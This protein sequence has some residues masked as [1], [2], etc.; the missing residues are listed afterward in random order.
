MEDQAKT[1]AQLIAELNELREQVV[2]SRSDAEEQDQLLG[3]VMGSVQEGVIVYGPDL[4]YRFWNQFMEELTGVPASKI[5]GRPSQEVFPFLRKVGVIDKLDQALAGMVPAPT[6]YAY[7][8]PESGRSG[9][10]YDESRPLRN[11]DG[12]IIGVIAIVREITER[13]RVEQE[14]IREKRFLDTA[15]DTQV[16]TFFLFDPATGKAVYWNRAFRDVSGYTD[17]E[18]GRMAAP[19]SYYSTDDLKRAAVFIEQTLQKKT[20]TIELELICKDGRKVLSEYRVG[21]V[22]DANGKPAY[23]VSIG[24][25]ITERKHAEDALRESE[26]HFQQLFDHMAAGVAVYQEVDEGQDFV[27]VDMN[28]TGQSF[29]KVR[30]EDVVGRRVAEVFPGVVEIGLLDVLR[31]VC[32][33]GQPEHHPLMN[34]VDGRI[35]LWVENYVYK[36]PSGLVVAIW[37]DTTAQKQAEA[38]ASR[39]QTELQ[40]AQKMEAIG[41]LAG[42]VAH[43]FNNQLGGI[44][45]YAELL[46]N[47]TDDEELR[48]FIDSI[49]RLCT[50][51]GELTNQLLAFSRKG[52]YRVVPVSM[53]QIVG[54]VASML[55]HSIDRRIQIRQRLN[56]NPRTTTGD[57][58]QLQNALLNLGL[59]ARDAMPEGG[60]LVFATDTV[61]LDE[62]HCRNSSFELMP[63]EYVRTKVTDSGTGMDEETQSRAFEPFFTTKGQ[64]KG[65]GMGLAAVFGT[66]V[67]HH[68]AIEVESEIGRGTTMTVYLPLSREE[69]RE[70]EAG[71][72]VAAQAATESAGAGILVVDDE[73]V[74]RECTARMLRRKGYRVATCKDGAEA[75]DYYRKSW[76]H[77]DLVI[78]DMNMPVMN[79]HDAFI[80]MRG[81]NA[82][83]RAM[84]ATG[85]SLDDN[86]QEILHEGALSYIQKP[87]QMHELFVQVEQALG[88]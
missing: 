1:K 32:R 69:P 35:E 27:F 15:L 44:M 64:D 39:L 58:T 18:I 42:G 77:I 48:P 47:K 8:V 50:R 79:G 70:A 72:R 17:E 25:D 21:T 6:E 85:Y 74:V 40:Q 7:S 31:R 61:A 68:G 36:L 55:N 30:L 82:G 52:Q 73:E 54:E 23:L 38:E 9:W 46:L 65:T 4:Q 5:L 26:E 60:E 41:Q 12:E 66:V 20:G 33:T 34:Y 10:V 43:D 11:R 71:G 22:L 29:S 62:E 3:Q 63:G 87:F 81:I 88:R 86:A 67:N 2:E 59:N 57:P 45:G 16:D 78:L 28:E 80:A 13:K 53:H 84:L 24:R 37:S 14:L 83:I 49:I 56:A 76:Q 75:V 51:S 19:S